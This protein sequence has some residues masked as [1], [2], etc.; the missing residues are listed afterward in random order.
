[1][2]KKETRM[3]IVEMCVNLNQSIIDM[4]LRLS[5][6]TVSQILSKIPENEDVSNRSKSDRP[7]KL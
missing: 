3:K 7:Q 4:E 2:A 5:R 6:R 1:M